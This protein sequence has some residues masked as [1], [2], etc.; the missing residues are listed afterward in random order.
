MYRSKNP[1]KTLFK[2]LNAG[3]I[4]RV[5]CRLLDGASDAAVLNSITSIL[6]VI[7]PGKVAR[8]V[9]MGET[10]FGIG[11]ALGKLK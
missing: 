1:L 7:Y 6:M 5:V 9:A 10:L 4:D 3:E 8:V 11:L 2:S